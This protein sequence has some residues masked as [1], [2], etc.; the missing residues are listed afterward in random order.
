MGKDSTGGISMVNYV[1]YFPED[2]KSVRLKMKTW[3]VIGWVLWVIALIIG[4]LT[5]VDIF[6]FPGVISSQLRPVKAEE[7]QSKP[8]EPQQHGS[9]SYNGVWRVDTE[10]SFG[11]CFLIRMENGKGL[12]LTAKHVIQNVSQISIK[13]QTNTTYPANVICTVN[14]ED[15]ALIRAEGFF[16]EGWI[17]PLGISSNIRQ[18][19]KILVVGWP[20][21]QSHSVTGGLVSSIISDPP[22]IQ[23]DAATN[24]GNSGGPLISENQSAVV[25]IIVQSMK[26]AE[27]MHYAVPIDVAKELIRSSCPD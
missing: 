23:T 18:G 21:G 25:G 24:P 17:L 8:E 7:L 19:D 13:S 5:V 22:R 3:I 12:F 1:K 16:E 2:K 4:I 20:L 11:S 27:G 9:M 15:V 14:D 26:E 10:R 6:L